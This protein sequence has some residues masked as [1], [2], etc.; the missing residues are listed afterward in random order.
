VK[1]FEKLHANST[2]QIHSLSPTLMSRS[3]SCRS[4]PADGGIVPVFAGSYVKLIVSTRYRRS[5][6]L[7]AAACEVTVVTTVV[8]GPSRYACAP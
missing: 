7:V 8:V 2:V 6:S 4:G 3:S 1:A 5:E